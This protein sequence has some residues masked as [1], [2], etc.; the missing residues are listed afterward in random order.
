L[1]SSPCRE[2]AFYQL[3]RKTSAN[4]LSRWIQ[5]ISINSRQL[6]YSIAFE[7]LF[8]QN[9]LTTIFIQETPRINS[10]TLLRPSKLSQ[11]SLAFDGKALCYI[12]HQQQEFAAGPAAN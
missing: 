9:L 3:L 4:L 5:T 7:T 10:K 6:I 1:N 11:I 2:P 8:H 12:G